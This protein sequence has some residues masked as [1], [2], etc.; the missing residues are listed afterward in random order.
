MFKTLQAIP[1]P[2]LLLFATTLEVCGDAVVR[3]AIY[4]H[5]GIVRGVLFLTGA[6]LLLGYGSCLNTAPV[7]FG[8]IVGLYIATLFIVWQIITFVVF[9]APPALPVRVGGVLVIAGGLII[10][11][12]RPT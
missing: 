2:L 8:R 6:V 5:A 7:D 3:L 12:W 1:I 9:R 10:T 11:F 4:D